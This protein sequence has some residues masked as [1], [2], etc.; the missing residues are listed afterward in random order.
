M[1]IP[2]LRS[3]VHAYSGEPK[4]GL[5]VIFTFHP[6]KSMCMQTPACVKFIIKMKLYR[7]LLIIVPLLDSPVPTK[8]QTL[9]M[10]LKSPC[11]L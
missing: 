7:C 6:F 3:L 2:M 8:F 5:L 9:V 4:T 11:P 1:L 10:Q